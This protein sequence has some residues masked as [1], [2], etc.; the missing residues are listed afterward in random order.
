MTALLV[1]ATGGHLA[2]LDRLA[3]RI[4]EV[5]RDTVWATFDTPQSRALL[6]DRPH[7]FVPY[8]G[9]R[10]VKSV[11]R[12]AG[13]AAR[14]IRRVKPD[15]VISTGNAIAVSFLPVARILGVPAAYIESAA[16]ATGP[17]VTGRIVQWVPGVQLYTQYPG[18][19]RGRW[20][21]VGS[22]FDQF[23][24]GGRP[25][26]TDVRRMFVTLGTIGYS[27]RRLV[28][29]IL[30]IVPAGCDVIW[31]VGA[32]DVSELHIDAVK[33]M[34]PSQM[35]Q[36]VKRADVVVAHAGIGSA[37][38]AFDAGR[39]PVL[40]PRERAHGEHVDDHQAQIALALDGLGLAIARRAEELQ[41][42]DLLVAA[43]RSVASR[44]E[45]P[46]IVLGR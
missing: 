4:V 45:P 6:R 10:D 35:A 23:V 30:A 28:E 15:V 3:P 42:R 33:T 31:Q 1:A 38:A 13:V 22:V 18:W 11:L 14:L 8:T 36:E 29:R 16:R 43:R 39:C 21:S 46:R 44:R 27:F 7:V 41:A 17:S 34:S 40:V 26:D 20:R 25:V 12:N 37:L 5:D 32:T 19:A 24:P 2:Q 9:P